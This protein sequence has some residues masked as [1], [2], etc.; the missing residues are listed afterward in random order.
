ML[1]LRELQHRFA[2]AVISGDAAGIE[3]AVCADAPG[4]AARVGI[5]ANHFRI[6]LI[7][8]LA[9]NFP[10]VRQLVGE[11]F[12]SAAA[13]RHILA[14]PPVDPRL[15]AYGGGFP[16]FLESLPE[17]RPVPYLADV[18]R[19][20]WAI[21]QAWHAPDHDPAAAPPGLHPSCRLVASPFPI[22]RIWQ[23]HQGC[24]GEIE[25]IDLDAGAVRLLVSRQ[26]GEVGWIH[27][28]PAAFGFLGGLMAQATG[29][30]ALAA[31][32]ALDP[33]FDPV[34]LLAALIE[35][36]LFSSPTSTTLT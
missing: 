19:L 26:D 18:A 31:A 10:V 16:S 34:P 22:D 21:N 5:Y 24:A 35:A 1:S 15:F 11:G 27:L 29:E 20:E 6:T 23:A 36:G 28:P 8:A 3:A 30:D 25:A 9:A 32:Q 4:A 17:A 7:E 2:A 33:S 12:F 14:E 13:R